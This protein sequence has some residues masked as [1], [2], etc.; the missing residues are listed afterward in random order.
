MGVDKII[1]ISHLQNIA[2][3][4]ALA[5]MLRDIDVMIAGGGDEL[6]RN[7]WNPLSPGDAPY[8]SSVSIR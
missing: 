5:P 3:D 6:L 4:Q 7:S 8:R 2:E 1:L